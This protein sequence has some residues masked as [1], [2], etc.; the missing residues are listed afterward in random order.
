MKRKVYSKH[1]DPLKILVKV[2]PSG[3]RRTRAGSTPKE[4]LS[5]WICRFPLELTIQWTH[6]HAMCLAHFCLPV[7]LLGS[8]HITI[9]N[10][11]GGI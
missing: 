3:L 1:G 9:P 10:S 5:R 6:P 7:N 2:N 8:F 11:R 4:N